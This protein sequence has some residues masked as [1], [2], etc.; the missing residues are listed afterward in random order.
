MLLTE[1]QLRYKVFEKVRAMLNEGAWGYE[2]DDSDSFGYHDSNLKDDIAE[3]VYDTCLDDIKLARKQKRDFDKGNIYWNVVGL[4]E[5][6]FDAIPSFDSFRE[7]KGQEK[8]YVWWKLI[9]DR[10]KNIIKLYREAV[11]ACADAKGWIEEWDK[12]DKMRK[13]L[14]KRKKI[15]AKYEKLL[16]DKIKQ[17]E[18]YENYRKKHN[19][20][21]PKYVKDDYSKV[22]KKN[23]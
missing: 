10:K 17:E 4:I 23:R 22:L 2:P 16:D 9:H 6:Y 8:Y 15:L 21:F 5:K 19:F 1:A 3:M 20:T 14:A 13:S 12:P 7:E 11:E 18:K